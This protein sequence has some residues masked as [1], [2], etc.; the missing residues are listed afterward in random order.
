MAKNRAID[1]LAASNRHN[2]VLLV[3][4]TAQIDELQQLIKSLEDRT[5][6]SL[7][8]EAEQNNEAA[9]NERDKNKLCQIR[10]K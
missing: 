2:E 7:R 3:R 10:Y 4:Q 9:S 8:G 6:N 5:H 1:T